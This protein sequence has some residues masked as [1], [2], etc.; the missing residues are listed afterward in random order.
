MQTSKQRGLHVSQSIQI[1]NQI[2]SGSNTIGCLVRLRN[3]I[4]SQ[5][6]GWQLGR[7]WTTNRF[8]SGERGCLF[9]SGP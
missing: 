7:K 4:S 9:V 2:F 1:T 5:G 3:P 8:K 6:S